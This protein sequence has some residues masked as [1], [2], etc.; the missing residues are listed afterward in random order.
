MPS[1]CAA[2]VLLHLSHRALYSSGE[3]GCAPIAA[4]AASCASRTV[5]EDPC[6]AST[7]TDTTACASRIT[8]EDSCAS[9]YAAT[10][11]RAPQISEEDSCASLVLSACQN[12]GHC[13]GSR[14]SVSE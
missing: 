3:D 7:S 10:A 1:P 6:G 13:E 11:S 4:D 14:A 12:D 2:I 8:E 9:M 5:G